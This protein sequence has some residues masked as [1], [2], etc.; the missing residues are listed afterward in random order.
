VRFERLREWRRGVA[1]AAEL[2]AFR[3]FPD[4]ALWAMARLQPQSMAELRLVP[5]IGTRRADQ[6]GEA[7][8]A[9]LRDAQ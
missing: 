4:R 2:P 9:V 5:G 1:R 3:V 7:V 8:L 6:Y